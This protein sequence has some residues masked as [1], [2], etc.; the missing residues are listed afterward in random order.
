M[1]TMG[2]PLRGGSAAASGLTLPYTITFNGYANYAA[3]KAAYAAVGII[4][5][6]NKAERTGEPNVTEGMYYGTIYGNGG[7]GVIPDT[8]YNLEPETPYIFANFFAASFPATLTFA[9]PAGTQ[10]KRVSY[11][12]WKNTST[13]ITF[14]ALYSDTSTRVWYQ[15]IDMQDSPFDRKSAEP[16]SPAPPGGAVYMTSL[17]I[18]A[19]AG[20]R[21]ALDNIIFTS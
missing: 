9:L 15:S 11:D 18:S 12:T 20:C 5:S 3:M 19:P 8:P 21:L 7:S 14:T 2:A 1:F 4:I 10:A 6:S 17:T 16:V 13:E